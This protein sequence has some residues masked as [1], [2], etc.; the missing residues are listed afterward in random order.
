MSTGFLTGVFLW[1]RHS[2]GSLLPYLQDAAY[3]EIITHD[4]MNWWLTL[5]GTIPVMGLLVMSAVSVILGDLFGK[6]WSQKPSP[7]LFLLAL[8]AYLLSGWFYI[9]TLRRES[10]VLTSV[11]WTVLSTTGFLAIGLLL[12]HE[13]LSP[14]QGIGVFFGVVSLILLSI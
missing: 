13:S 3:P 1:G 5:A 8:M 14:L 4:P 11:I 9:P 2:G 6:L 7:L 12:F 10:L